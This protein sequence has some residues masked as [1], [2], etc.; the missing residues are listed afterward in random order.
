MRLTAPPPRSK[1]GLYLIRAS[2]NRP[3]AAWMKEQGL[4]A[5][6]YVKRV[7]L[8]GDLLVDPHLFV[9]VILWRRFL[10][11]VSRREVGRGLGWRV[12]AQT[13]AWEIDAVARALSRGG[14]VRDAIRSFCSEILMDAPTSGYGFSESAAGSFFW[15][16]PPA[17]PG[18]EIGADVTEQYAAAMMVKTIQALAGPSWRPV[19]VHLQAEHV[20]AF[21]RWVL[22][23]PEV[24]L[25]APLTAVRL[26]PQQL[27]LPVAASVPD[28]SRE[29]HLRRDPGP[30][31]DFVGA[32]RQAIEGALPESP[33]VDWAADSAAVSRRTLQRRLAEHGLTWEHLVDEVR[34]ATA[35]RE[36]ARGNLSIRE[37]AERTGFRDPASFTRAFRRWTGSA[38]RDFRE[39]LVARDC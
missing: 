11:E 9:P 21:G 14:T 27:D 1:T 34:R 38:P 3:F 8:P 22:G 39:A 18:A 13:R 4:P 30:A 37:V 19:Q 16:R 10:A 35:C 33:G 31:M 12:G 17:T 24:V 2:E 26:Q 6:H 20:D 15:R 29:R 25:R 36:L 32:L 23:D 5:D 28:S 7:G